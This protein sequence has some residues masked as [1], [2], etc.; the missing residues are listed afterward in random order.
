MD[1]LSS[2]LV[3]QS[4]SLLCHMIHSDIVIMADW[5]LKIN[6]LSSYLTYVFHLHIDKRNVSLTMAHFQHQ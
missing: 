2:T 5:T 4:F 1:T 3:R 6:Y